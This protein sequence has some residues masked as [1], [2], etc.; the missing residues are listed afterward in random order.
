MA[1]HIVFIMAPTDTTS[2]SNCNAVSSEDHDLVQPVN[3]ENTY[4]VYDPTKEDA[5][6]TLSGSSSSDVPSTAS[7]V[8]DTVGESSSKVTGHS[9]QGNH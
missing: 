4:V 9:V 1:D 5:S 8:E 2:S 7:S 6:E 3:V